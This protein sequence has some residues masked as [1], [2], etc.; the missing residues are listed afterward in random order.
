MERGNRLNFQHP[1][2]A[3]VVETVQDAGHII[4][5]IYTR[6]FDVQNKAD[7]SPLTDADQAAHQLIVARLR[8]LTPDIPVLSE[9]ETNLYGRELWGQDRYWLV[10]PL[11]GT[12]EFIK[13][14][15]EFTVNIALIE[16]G[17]PVLGVVHS[18]ALGWSYAAAAGKGAFKLV[19][20]GAWQAIHC[21]K[22][23]DAASWRIVGSRSHAEDDLQAVLDRLDAYELV[24]M[25]SSLKLCLVAEGAADLYPRLGSTSLWDTA[26]A[27]CVVQ[28]AGGQVVDLAG[29]PLDYSNTSELLN[30]HFIAH[31]ISNMDWP[32]VFS[33]ANDR[34]KGN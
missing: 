23:V 6:S 11:D 13:R 20:E 18:P 1:W 33:G 8:A 17:C 32:I 21:T 12:K 10:D 14:N 9:E 25:G 3:A 29:T 4:M 26:A 2:L 28:E 30:P 7:N 19:N 24:P 15:G 22:H 5:A 34:A 16:Q 27:Q 31:G